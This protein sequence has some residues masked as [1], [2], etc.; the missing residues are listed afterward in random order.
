MPG[1]PHAHHLEIAVDVAQREAA[2]GLLHFQRS[3]VDGADV[4]R[5]ALR[6][7]HLEVHAYSGPFLAAVTGA[8]PGP[9]DVAAAAARVAADEETIR[10]LAEVERRLRFGAGLLHRARGDDRDVIAVLGDDVNRSGDVAQLEY[11]PIRP[12]HGAAN[13][14]WSRCGRQ[15]VAKTRQKGH[16]RRDHQGNSLHIPVHDEL[17]MTKADR[18]PTAR[19]R[20]PTR[21]AMRPAPMSGRAR[22]PAD[23]GYRP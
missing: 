13:R 17:L 6:Q 8:V 2:L 21:R 5:G 19:G 23:R 1:A 22:R 14:F 11:V 3:A 16:E 15:P 9:V 20:A 7:A 4:Q 18:G 12:R 10:L